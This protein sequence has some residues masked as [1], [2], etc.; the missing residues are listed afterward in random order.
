MQSRIQ[1]GNDQ[2]AN[3]AN[4]AQVVVQKKANFGA[5]STR[6]SSK[7]PIQAKQRPIQAKQR[8]IQTKQRPLQRNK[9][10]NNS[11]GNANEAQIKANVSTLTGTDVTDAQVTYNSSKPMQLQAEATAQGNQVHLGPGKEQHLGHEL[12]HVAQQKQ[13]RVQPTIQANNG[14]GINNDPKLEKEADDIGAQATVMSSVIQPK[15]ITS[16]RTQTIAKPVI[17]AKFDDVSEENFRKIGNYLKRYDRKPIFYK[18][19]I[20]QGKEDN[21][22]LVTLDEWIEQLFDEDKDQKLIAK[23]YE[24]NSEEIEEN[25]VS[26]FFGKIKSAVLDNDTIDQDL[27]QMQDPVQEPKVGTMKDFLAK[28]QHKKN[29]LKIFA[30]TS[31]GFYTQALSKIE[32]SNAS[33]LSADIQKSIA[34]YQQIAAN[35]SRIYANGG[36]WVN[37]IQ[38]NG[39]SESSYQI[40]ALNDPTSMLLKL[41]NLADSNQDLQKFLNEQSPAILR[42][43]EVACGTMSI[44]LANRNAVKSTLADSNESI[45]R[46]D[47]VFERVSKQPVYNKDEHYDYRFGKKTEKDN[48][49]KNITGNNVVQHALGLCYLYTV[50]SYLADMNPNFVKS[51]FTEVSATHA[52]VRLFDL[53]GKPVYVKVQR[54]RILGKKGPDGDPLTATGPARREWVRLIE[55]A[56]V[57]AGFGG[58]AYS[59]IVPQNKIKSH[60]AVKGLDTPD[61]GLGIFALKHLTG[62]T[63]TDIEMG[64]DEGLQAVKSALDKGQYVGCGFDGKSKGLLKKHAYRIVGYESGTNEDYFIIRNPHARNIPQ[65]QNDGD[66][67]I[68]KS[69]YDHTKKVD[70]EESQGRFVLT[71][72]Q[73]KQYA[74]GLQIGQKNFSKIN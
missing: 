7:P 47:D 41:F 48:L 32:S 70:H 10:G 13:G 33:V 31:L 65:L 63:H 60:L 24:L 22:D 69:I 34:E 37:T 62:N 36:K 8:P 68:T 66:G 71:G 72:A 16:N 5:K 61:G 54:T 12:T 53:K 15:Q 26:N 50:M 1:H 20:A 30:K 52:T 45:T 59:K 3:Q 29:M 46:N 4:T 73:L 18:Q 57:T 39:A 35:P 9:G 2:E 44:S 43:S 27:D 14:V 64:D 56:F 67:D 42:E 49:T 40:G 25:S 58:D 17:Q 11:M 51:M 23:L 21:G 6:Q 28:Q 38:G 55:K 74:T 19:W